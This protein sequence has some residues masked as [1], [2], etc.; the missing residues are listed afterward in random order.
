MRFG[1]PD[2][3]V[4]SVA[5]V[6]ENNECAVKAKYATNLVPDQPETNAPL[7]CPFGY[8]AFKLYNF[9]LPLFYSRSEITIAPRYQDL[10]RDHFYAEV[11]FEDYKPESL[12]GRQ[13]GCEY[14]W[15]YGDRVYSFLDG[16][17]DASLPIIKDNGGVY[18]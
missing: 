14:L 12:D 18:K 2:E 8:L 5:S 17:L 1:R 15:K 11:T 6:E 9:D 3:V 13:E 7:A 16:R 4:W 10:Q